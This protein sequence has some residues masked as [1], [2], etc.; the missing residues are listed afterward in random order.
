MPST[1]CSSGTIDLLCVVI[2]TSYIHIGAGGAGYL[3]AATGAGA[4]VAGFGTAFLIG[5]RRRSR[6]RWC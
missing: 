6:A 1:S 4:V 2:A 3:N 5:R